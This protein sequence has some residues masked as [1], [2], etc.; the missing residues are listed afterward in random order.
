MG[1]SVDHIRRYCRLLV[2][3]HLRSLHFRCLDLEEVG[4]VPGQVVVDGG[5]GAGGDGGRARH[6]G[7]GRDGN[8]GDDD[9][10]GDD[11][12]RCLD[13]RRDHDGAYGGVGRDDVAD[14]HRC[15]RPRMQQVCDLAG[16][17]ASQWSMARRR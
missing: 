16:G 3:T 17:L 15:T 4:Q 11:R 2:D 13:T 7:H 1:D 10:G 6:R 5:D 12:G 14:S 8:R 9:D